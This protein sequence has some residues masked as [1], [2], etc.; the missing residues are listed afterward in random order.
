M[1]RSLKFTD[2]SSLRAGTLFCVAANYAMHA[3]EMGGNVPK[4]PSIFIKPPQSIINSGETIILPDISGNVHHEVELVVIIGKECYNVNK[5]EA[6]DYIAGYAVGI[7]VTMRDIQMQAKKEGKPWAIAKGFYTSAPLSEIV[8]ASDF[9][10]K[11]PDFELLLSINGEIK[12]NENTAQMVRDV[13]SLIEF[14]SGMFA[15]MPGDL[16]Y[17]G[18]PQGVGKITNGDL[19]HS[20]LKGYVSLDINVK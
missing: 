8:P 1:F 13:A 2:G 15:L 9:K 20:E 11:I 4:A 3:K 19:I 12:Q 17:T 18:T 16:I 6:I 10:G 14:L 5:N 7:D